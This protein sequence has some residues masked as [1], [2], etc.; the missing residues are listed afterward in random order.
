M[1]GLPGQLQ[2][3]DGSPPPRSAA[4]SNKYGAP[5]SGSKSPAAPEDAGSFDP[6]AWLH[7]AQHLFIRPSALLLGAFTGYEAANA[8]GVLNEQGVEVY[9]A[10]EQSG[11]AMRM[12]CGSTR[13][14]DV[15]LQSAPAAGLPGVRVLRFERPYRVRPPLCC[16]YLQEL[17]VYNAQDQPLGGVYQEW[18]CKGFIAFVRDQAGNELFNVQGPP[19]DC[20]CCDSDFVIYQHEGGSQVGSI[21]TKYSGSLKGPEVLVEQF[22]SGADNFNIEMPMGATGDERSLLLGAAFLVNLLFAEQNGVPSQ[23]EA[24]GY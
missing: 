12:C 15:V 17:V 19:F 21:T 22:E 13:A 10:A 4:G 16:C 11:F 5:S 8:F 14:L 20:M 3:T 7:S 6:L 1:A 24:E 2:L 9:Q 18:R 23:P